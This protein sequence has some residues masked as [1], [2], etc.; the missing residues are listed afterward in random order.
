MSLIQEIK[1]GY[2]YAKSEKYRTRTLHGIA[3]IMPLKRKF[4]V[5]MTFCGRVE[6]PATLAL[7]AD[8]GRCVCAI[9]YGLKNRQTEIGTFTDPQEQ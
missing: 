9:S 8:P 4:L 7:L 2:A 5:R 1:D 3:L 6:V